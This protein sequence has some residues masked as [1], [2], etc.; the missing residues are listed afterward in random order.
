MPGEADRLKKELADAN[1]WIRRLAMQMLDADREIA[2]L[3]KDLARDA[4]RIKELEAK[5]EEQG[6]ALLDSYRLAMEAEIAGSDGFEADCGVL[7]TE[8]IHLRKQI[9]ELEERCQLEAKEVADLTRWL[10][11]AG[12]KAG[13]LKQENAQLVKENLQLIQEKMGVLH[14]DAAEKPGHW[15]PEGDLGLTEQKTPIWAPALNFEDPLRY[16]D[17][18]SAR[19][20]E[21]VGALQ[22]AASKQQQFEADLESLAQR[23]DQRA[24]ALRVQMVGIRGRLDEVAA[25]YDAWDLIRDNTSARLTGVEVAQRDLFSRMARLERTEEPLPERRWWWK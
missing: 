12:R 17:D 24:E 23:E 16:C 18:L 25:A 21:L 4:A 6:L 5:V 11:E 2:R 8:N 13:E 10:D 1:D 7:A 9:A 20:D 22:A 3:G 15:D 14:V 19:V